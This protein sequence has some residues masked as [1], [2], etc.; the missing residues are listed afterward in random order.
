MISHPN[1]PVEDPYNIAIEL[2][3]RQVGLIRFFVY[4]NAHAAF[5]GVA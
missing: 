1:P 3:N 5:L 2:Y 4:F